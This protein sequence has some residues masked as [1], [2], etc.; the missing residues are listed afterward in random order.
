MRVWRRIPILHRTWVGAYLVITDTNTSF[1]LNHYTFTVCWRWLWLLPGNGDHCY[2][3]TINRCSHLHW[4]CHGQVFSPSREQ[5][6]QLSATPVHLTAVATNHASAKGGRSKP[7]PRKSLG[8]NATSATSPTFPP[9]T[10]GTAAGI[11]L[12]VVSS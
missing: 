6:P 9:C 7:P 5:S 11:T 3:R 10:L 12:P 1:S 8:V 2:I 4:S